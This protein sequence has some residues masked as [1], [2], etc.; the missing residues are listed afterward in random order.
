V[1]S[2]LQDVNIDLDNYELPAPNVSGDIDGVLYDSKRD[3]L[4]QLAA[5]KHHRRGG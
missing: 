5:Y 3:Y 1:E 4:D 2:D